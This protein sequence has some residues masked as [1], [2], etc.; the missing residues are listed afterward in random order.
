MTAVGRSSG[1][2]P[3]PPPGPRNQWN[4]DHPSPYPW[5]QDALDH[6]RALMPPAEPYR[7]WATFTFTAQSGR[8]NEC[9]LLIAV[10][11]GLYLV[12]IKSHPGR[13]ENTGST[14]NFHGPDRMR[15]IKNPLHFTDAKS[16]DL[17][18]Q[19]Q[20]AGRRLGIRGPLP[21]IEPAV[22]LSATDLDSRLDEVQRLRVFGRDDGASRLPRIW[23]DFLGLP[24]ER[25][26][27]RITADFSQRD[28]P[29]MLKEIGI[30]QSTAHLRFGDAWR[31]QPHPLDIGRS[32][33]DRLAKRVDGLVHEEGRVRIYLVGQQPTDAAKKA[34]TRAATREYQVLQGIN[35]RG[36]AAAVEIREHLAG[37]A[38]LFRHR[39]TDLRLDQ[40]LD[41]HGGHLTPEMRLDLVR[42]LAEAVRYAHNRSLFH[43]A[44]SARSVYVSCRPDGSRPELRITDWQTAARDFDTNATLLRSLGN[45][46][47]DGGFIE[48]TAQVYLAPE[49]E[50]PHP[51]PVDLDIF[52]L[53]AVSYLILT[54]EPPAAE[55]SALR[56][57][58]AA[59]AGLRLIAVADGVSEQLDQLVFQATQADPDLRLTPV[60][61]F[62]ELLDRAEEENTAPEP[63]AVVEVDPLTAQ[64]GQALDGEWFVRKT[65]G[66]GAT[67]RA[68]LVERIVEDEEGETHVEERVFKV[69][70][71]QEKAE[72]LRAE[73]RALAEVGGG[74][75]VQLR[76]TLEIGGRPLLVLEYAGEQTLG[77]RLRSKGKLSYHEL[78]RYGSDLF[79]ALDQLAAKGVRHRDIKPDN[80]GLYRREDRIWQLKLFDFS[81]A[82]VSDQDVSAG[83][84]GYLDPFLGS[85]RRSRYDDYAERYATAV[86]LHEMASGEKPLWGGG[87]SD[88]VAHEDAELTIADELFEPALADGLTA[89]FQRAL[90]RDTEQRFDTLRQMRD[91]WY[92]VFRAADARRP[93][94]TPDTVDTVSESVDAARDAA[95]EVAT[96]ETPLDAAGLSPRAV[97]VADGLGATVVRQ[98]ID[99]QPYIISKARGAGSLVRKELNRRRKQWAAVLRDQPVPAAVPPVADD[100]EEV[101]GNGTSAAVK[102]ASVDEMA[103]RLTPPRGRKNSHRSEVIRLIL[104]LPSVTGDPSPLGHWPM[105]KRVA[106]R[107]GIQQQP[108]SDH[109]RNAIAEWHALGWL[110]EVR[111]SLVEIV[112]ANGRVMTAQ[113]LAVKVRIR[114]GADSSDE[115]QV[116][117]HA[118][119]VVRA[120][121]EAEI[122]E[123][124]VGAGLHEP[125]LAWHRREASVLI[126]A[127]SLPGTDDPSPAELAD[128]AAALGQVAEGLAHQEPLPGRSAVVS[129]LRGVSAPAGLAPLA[130][131]R[132]VELAAAAAATAAASP[133]LELYPRDL[134]LERALRIS[135]VAVGVSHKNGITP[136]ELNSRLRARF[137][138]L[139][140]LTPGSEPTHVELGEALRDVRSAL[141]YDPERKRFFPP[142]VEQALTSWTSTGTSVVGSAVSGVEQGE[143][144]F[145][146]TEAQLA[147]SIRRGGFLAVTLKGVLLPGAAQAMAARHPVE[148]VDV[149]SA[150][151]AEFRR[152]AEE[153]NQPWEKVLG[154]D[155][156]FTSTGRISPGL[157]T[158]VR[159]VWRRVEARLLALAATPR[160]VLFLHDAGMLARYWDEGG[161]DLLVGL[162]AAARR[163][164][165]APHG[166]WL[167]APVETRSQAPN[168]DGRTVECIGGDAERIHLDSEYVK[169]LPASVRSAV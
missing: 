109:H 44:L 20:W 7:A 92:E 73:A 26:E 108:V 47:I 106:D 130:D 149:G 79:T 138:D 102:P 105:Q 155:A 84:R 19:L 111:A 118:G 24:P 13:L 16:K 62:I 39:G 14:W 141:V 89:F 98:L 75:V 53:G 65:L 153:R 25:P 34:T 28:L 74:N 36:I 49:Y 112:E 82:E 117:A 18:S 86:T 123:A 116:L 70:L 11:A 90:H 59:D 169:A 33:E 97:S 114:Y 60:D 46:S 3:G 77:A 115:Q 31:M 63:S 121:V 27:R 5:E 41:T 10:P 4:Q 23:Q 80:L 61:R 159:E 55:R 125:R 17:K 113:E 157:A 30:R 163:P 144:P 43:R 58:L 161:R 158:Y 29:R 100:R 162:Q 85:V 147:A 50:Q 93:V 167:L 135:Q 101:S 94:T 152:L 104:G 57:R 76:G 156:R 69:A 132:L 1:P 142:A 32:W 21:R 45:E 139:G 22:F 122:W 51:D 40:Y 72:R 8:I 37:P 127:E 150:F 165:Q 148:P 140:L 103:A 83:T 67:A 95:A 48:D 133:R 54:G 91:A 134:S 129:R 119:A 12:E 66:T 87:H 128:Y 78:E 137:P 9:D 164:T 88:P 81:L 120:A 151:L 42:Q 166:L 38:I 96:L 107:I 99:I 160:T 2:K 52:G 168:L 136:H 35:H 68:L 6:V 146:G 56:E 71:D 145:A 15:T 143:D 110:A 64:P 124:K 126:A 131:T 154:I